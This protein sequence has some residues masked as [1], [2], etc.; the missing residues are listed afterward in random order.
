MIFVF[1]FLTYF[2][3][4]DN[5]Q[6]HPCCCND[7][8]SFFFMPEYKCIYVLAIVNSDAMNM[9]VHYLFELQLCLDIYSGVRLVDHMIILLQFSEESSYC[10]SEWLYQLIFPPTV[11]KGS[12][13]TTPPPEFVICRLFK[14]GHSDQCEVGPH[15]SFNLHF[16][17]NQQC[18]CVSWPYVFLLWI[19]VYIGLLHIF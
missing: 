14:D 18:L 11:Q 3:Q 12:L 1:L 5:L 17:N 19:N 6:L 2:T 4:Y 8:I 15:C 7:S 16:S 9:V 10:F 13:F